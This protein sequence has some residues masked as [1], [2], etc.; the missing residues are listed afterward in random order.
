MI[1]RMTAGFGGRDAS[2]GYIRTVARH[3]FEH[4]SR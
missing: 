1:T 4:V 2:M 3:C